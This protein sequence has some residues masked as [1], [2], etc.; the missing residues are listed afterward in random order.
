METIKGQ[1]RALGL[2]AL[3]N[4]KTSIAGVF[5]ILAALLPAH[6]R[7]IAEIA[8]GFGLIFAQDAG[9]VRK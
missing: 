1:L 7:E 9:S 8:A 4:P 3:D 5:A 6:A 2:R